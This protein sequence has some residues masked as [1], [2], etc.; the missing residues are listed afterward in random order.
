MTNTVVEERSDEGTRRWATVR[1]NRTRVHQWTVFGPTL[2][3]HEK[4]LNEAF[5]YP[6]EVSEQ[7][8]ANVDQR[9]SC[10]ES[11]PSRRDTPKA[12]NDPLIPPQEIGVGPEILLVRDLIAATPVL[13][14]I[15]WI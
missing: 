11:F 13:D 6:P 8:E 15:E 1:S 14:S 5:G 12:I 4:A 9:V 7:G 3:I 10:C 2:W